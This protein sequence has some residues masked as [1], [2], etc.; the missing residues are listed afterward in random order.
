[1]PITRII[2]RSGGCN[3]LAS[4]RQAG[5]APEHLLVARCVEEQHACPIR[6]SRALSMTRLNRTPDRPRSN[7]GAS[8][9]CAFSKIPRASDATCRNVP[10]V[11]E[12]VARS[13]SSGIDRVRN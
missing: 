8:K 3:Y 1:M 13:K 9:W 11:T 2:V 5:C 4:E 10:Q 12:N 7:L 6:R